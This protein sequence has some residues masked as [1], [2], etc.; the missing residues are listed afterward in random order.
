MKTHGMAPLLAALLA[1]CATATVGQAQGTK[2]GSKPRQTMAQPAAVVVAAKDTTAADTVVVAVADTA[3]KKKHGGL[4]GKMKGIAKNKVVLQVAKVA[5]CT[6]VPGGQVVAGAIDAASNKG[7]AGA[8]QGV[9]GAATGSSCMPGGMSAAGMTGGA[10]MG[11]SVAQMAAMH[12]GGAGSLAG[13]AMMAGQMQQM[14]QMMASQG[15]GAGAMA[16]EAPGQAIELSSD[17]TADLTKGKTAVRNIDW[18]AGAAGVSVAGTPGFTEAM[19]QLAAAMGQ[20]GG[21][22]RLDLYL[23]GRYEDEIVKTLGAERLSLLQS[24]LSGAPNA[25]APAPVLELGKIKKDKHPRLEI[26]RRK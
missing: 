20:V 26:V 11:M 18:V 1:V 24:A 15:A 14:Q 13:Q 4:F 7:T 5:A 22:Y 8:A 9:A 25:A 2:K 17:L 19:A 21:S 6:M 12:G 23:D 3:P 16:T 10:A